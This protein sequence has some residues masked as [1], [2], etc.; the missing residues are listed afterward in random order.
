MTHKCR[1]RRLHTPLNSQM[2]V[3]SSDC[4]GQ[5]DDHLIAETLGEDA[6]I[7]RDEVPFNCLKTASKIGLQ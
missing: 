3:V 2:T 4:S 6:Q 1:N 5:S 7:T